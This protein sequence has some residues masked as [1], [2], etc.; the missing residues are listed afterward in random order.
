MLINLKEIREPTIGLTNSIQPGRSLAGAT[1]ARRLIGGLLCRPRAALNRRAGWPGLATLP[2][3]LAMFLLAQA[4]NAH[5]APKTLL[6]LGDSLSAEYGL[7][8][9]AGWVSLFEQ[10]LKSEKLD[11]TVVNASISGETTSGGRMRLPTLLAKR[12]PDIV[13]VELGAN[14]A[15]RGLPLAA[16]EANLRAICEESVKAGSRVLLIG[17]RIPPNYGRDYAERF[18]AVYGKVAA[19]CKSPL[20]PFM[21][22]GIAE[23]PQLFQA[24][25]MHPLAS[26]HPMILNNILPQLLPMIKSR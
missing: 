13:V 4:A 18:H 9:G 2:G 25:R 23:K 20:V 14:D 6:V 21:L 7:D 1:I 24:D 15:L 12:R 17:M 16:T 22:E 19:D 3:L 11:A 26:A 8:R 5:S 10:K